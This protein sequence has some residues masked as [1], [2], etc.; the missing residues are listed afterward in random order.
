MPVLL[1]REGEDQAGQHDAI[2]EERN[3][4]GKILC[5]FGLH[6][7]VSI[8]KHH[9]EKVSNPNAALCSECERCG[10]W[11]ASSPFGRVKIKA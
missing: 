4:M 8:L 5:I 10:A 2:V 9:P 1:E 6:K 11:F 3:P 7:L